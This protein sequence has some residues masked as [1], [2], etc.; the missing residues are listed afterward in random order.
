[1]VLRINN[2]PTQLQSMKTTCQCLCMKHEAVRD[3]KHVLKVGGTLFTDMA[4]LVCAR[5]S[6]IWAVHPEQAVLMRVCDHGVCERMGH[7]IVLAAKDCLQA[8]ARLRW[9]SS[10]SWWSTEWVVSMPILCRMP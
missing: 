8:L 6:L 5:D 9:F 1:M 7:L 3:L 2:V 4:H 10:S